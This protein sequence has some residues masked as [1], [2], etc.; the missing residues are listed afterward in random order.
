MKLKT[1]LI[2]ALLALIVTAAFAFDP[3]VYDVTMYAGEDF[4]LTLLLKDSGGATMNLTGNTYAAQFRSAP[5]P[6]GT[7]FATYSASAPT[8][9][10]GQIEVKLSRTQTATNTGKAGMWDLRQTDSTGMVSYLLT[11]KA[12]VKPTVTR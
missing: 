7:V 9:A 11:G 4:K 2:S 5:A 10:N 6:A 1:L 3:G 8:P 12:A